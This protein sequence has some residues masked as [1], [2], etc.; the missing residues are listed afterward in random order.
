L[1]AFTKE[2]GVLLM[3]NC[4]SHVT[5]D[6]IGLLTEAGVRVI[7][8]APYTTQNFQ[9]LDVTLFDVLKRRLGYKLPFED[10]KETVRFRMKVCHDFKQTM[11]ESNICR[12]LQVIGFEFDTEPEPYRLLF[13]GEKLRQSE[14]CRELWFI[15]FPWDQLSSRRQNVR[16]DWINKQE[17]S[18]LA[19]MK[20]SFIDQMPRYG[21]VSENE[22]VELWRYSPYNLEGSRRI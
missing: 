22:K 20:V 17:E 13:N 6:I 12:V 15:D 19:Q 21:R 2:T 14:G 5:D 9:V 3:D 1:D 16:F 10:E 7:T 4:P 11:V 8:F 18:D